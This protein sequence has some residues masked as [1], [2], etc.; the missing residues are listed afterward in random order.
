MI[1]VKLNVKCVTGNVILVNLNKFVHLV[2][3]NQE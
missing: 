2:L 1:L 3:K